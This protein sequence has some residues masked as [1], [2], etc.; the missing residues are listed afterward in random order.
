[1]TKQDFSLL[2]NEIRQLADIRR[3]PLRFVFA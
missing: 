2:V 1:V 3:D